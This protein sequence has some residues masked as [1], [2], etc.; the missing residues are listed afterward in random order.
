MS[1]KNSILDKKDLKKGKRFTASIQARMGST[2]LPGKVLMEVAGKPLLQIMVERARK[3]FEAVRKWAFM[4]S[5]PPVGWS[6]AFA[7]FAVTAQSE[8]RATT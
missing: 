2:R 4:V 1:H 5:R 7:R 8:R 6:W 3:S